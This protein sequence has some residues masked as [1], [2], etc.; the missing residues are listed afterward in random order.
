MCIKH[1]FI[2]YKKKKKKGKEFEITDIKKMDRENECNWSR[3]INIVYF[4]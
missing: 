1:N 4:I 2:E 3:D